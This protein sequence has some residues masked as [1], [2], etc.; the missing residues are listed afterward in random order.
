MISICFS[1]MDGSGKSTQYRKTNK[2][3]KILLAIGIY[4][5]Y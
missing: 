5:K 2:I 1:G 3:S 4:F